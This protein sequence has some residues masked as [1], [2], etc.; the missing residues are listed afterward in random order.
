VSINIEQLRDEVVRPTLKFIDRWSMDAERLVI[1]T[2][3][4][5]SRGEYL[6]QLNGGPALGLW[7]ME[8]ATEADIW[9]NYLN[10]RLDG[11]QSLPARVRS[12]KATYI[13]YPIPHLIASLPYACAMC[14]VHYLRVP[15]PL[16][17][18]PHGAAR[19]W[20]DH[21]NTHKGAG[22]VE[23]AMPWFEQAWRL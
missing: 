7:Q 5:E 2:A 20:K 14:R 17:T 9:A 15:E 16:P 13:G 22:T 3:L 21:Y 23:K 1:G 8:P 10:F 18:T 12:L 19:Y 6:R 4:V 11:P